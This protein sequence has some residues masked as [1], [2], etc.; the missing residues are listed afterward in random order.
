M[1]G[2]DNVPAN[3]CPDN[4]PGELLPLVVMSLLSLMICMVLI[5]GGIR[6]SFREQGHL[7]CMCQRL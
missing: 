5:F 3:A 7:Q 6:S 1:T 2:R 4:L